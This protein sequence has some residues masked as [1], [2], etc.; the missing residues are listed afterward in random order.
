MSETFTRI[1]PGPASG[2]DAAAVA[3]AVPPE[4][5]PAD[6][7]W[8]A[9]NMIA[10]ADGRTTIAGRAGPIANR[11]DYELFHALRARA[12][13]VMVGAATVRAE[14][15]GAMEQKAVLLS[16]SLDVPA[17]V[18]ML[19]APGND[20]VVLTPSPEGELPECEASVRY[21]REPDLATGL[22]RLHSEYGIAT[23]VCE[24]G[25]TINAQLLPLGVIDEL[26]LVVAAKLAGGL[27]PLT[28]V[29]GAA[30]DPVIELELVSVHESGGFLF[31]RYG[32]G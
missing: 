22:R 6:R 19:R 11:A 29:E 15:Y 4:E 1:F 21:L 5:L 23:I 31:L 7:P 30:F 10:T 25:P 16:R 17:T 28:V 9:L 3:A 20:V 18:G 2:L 24:G 26:H 12:D 14:S 32:V 13:A 8:V 27:D